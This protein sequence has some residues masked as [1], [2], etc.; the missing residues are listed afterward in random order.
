MMVF[1]HMSYSWTIKEDLIKSFSKHAKSNNQSVAWLLK[2]RIYYT[3]NVP[4]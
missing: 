1:W 4:C 2:N 3:V